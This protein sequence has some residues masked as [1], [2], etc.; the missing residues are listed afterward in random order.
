MTSMVFA[1]AV[2]LFFAM[3]IG[4][5]GTASSMGAAYGGGAIKRAWAALVLVGVAV[6]LGAV[7]GGGPVVK[8]LS[9]GLISPSVI[10]IHVA[11]IILAAACVTL[12]SANLLGIP[13]S[14][15]EVTVGAVL[16]VGI[17]YHSIHVWRVLFIAGVWIAMPFLA[18]VIAYVVGKFVLRAE[19]RLKLETRPA[20]MRTLFTLFLIGAGCYE[21]FSAGMNNVANAVGPLVGAKLV[22][23][24]TG[25]W[26][27]ALFVALGAV[28]LGRRVLETNAKRITDLSLMQG[29]LVSLTSGTLVFVSSL[30]GLPV[31]L[32]QATTM[33]IF[34]IGVS[35]R[36][37]SLWQQGIVKRILKIWIVS[38]VSALVVSYT[39]IEIFMSTDLYALIIVLSAVVMSVGYLSYFRQR[40]QKDAERQESARIDVVSMTSTSVPTGP[41]TGKNGN[42]DDPVA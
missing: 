33:A 14:T 34:G 22:S 17:A 10:N 18:F 29:S 23:V 41:F 40:G 11:I 26:W 2:A 30:Y 37:S 38:P 31:P 24:H 42:G 7:L 32:T 1:W 5:S 39:M 15:S 8:T 27:G 35:K 13:L 3:N 16:G 28:V 9:Q 36:G 19:N 12:F 25:I 6:F 4:A 20:W 21:A